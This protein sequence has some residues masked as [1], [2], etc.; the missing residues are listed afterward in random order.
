MGKRRRT[1][2]LP[3][4]GPAPALDL[5]SFITRRFVAPAS[6]LLVTIVYFAGFV[7]SGNVIEGI[8][9]RNEFYLGKEPMSKKLADLAPENWS[10]YLGGTPMSGFRKPNYFPLYPVYLFTTYHR[11]LGWRYFFAMFAAGYTMYLCAR[12]G[13]GIRPLPAWVTGAAY[14]FSPTLMTFIY[15]G[16]EGKMLV[17]GLLP[18]MVWSLYRGMDTRR[19]IYALILGAGVAAGIYTPHLQMLY[20][21]LL[22]LGLLFV[23]R[24]VQAYHKE[25]DAR[26]LAARSAIA[27]GG[28]CVGLAVGAVGTFPAYTYTKTES[29]RAGSDGAGVGLQ[30]AQSWSLH[31]EEIASLLVPEFVH[32]FRPGDRQNLYWGRNALKLNAEYFGIVSLLLALAALARIRGDDRIL[33]LAVVGTFALLFSLGP[34]TPVHSLFYHAVPGMNVLRVPGMI[35]F[36]IAFPAILLGGLL[37]DRISTG[38]EADDLKALKIATGALALPLLALFAAPTGAMDA[39]R[40]I[41]WPSISSEKAAIL[42]RNGTFLQNGA[43]LGLLWILGAFA[44]MYMGYRGRV[45]AQTVLVAILTVTAIDT[46]RIDKQF[47]R[48]LDPS[49]YPDPPVLHPNITR[50]LA[51]DDDLYRVLIGGTIQIPRTDLVTVPYHE[52]FSVRRYDAVTSKHLQSLPIL[53]LLNVRYLVTDRPIQVASFTSVAQDR[54]AHLYRNENALPFFYLVGSTTVETNEATIIERLMAPDF[55]LSQT[56]I[57]EVD[58]GAALS[59]SEGRVELLAFD[60]RAGRL[61]FQVASQTTQL[62]IVCQNY[63]PCW[64]AFVDGTPADLLRANYLWQGVVVPPGSHTVDLVYEDGLAVVCRWISFISFLGLV[65]GLIVLYRKDTREQAA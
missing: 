45:A 65:V 62:L 6:F 12:G 28:I 57:L 8:D 30:Y 24:A 41:A 49:H 10:R 56:A 50:A 19:P 25:K 11:Y 64:S 40:G 2:N 61:S 13:L 20:Y 22:A 58:P 31:P 3:A 52:P 35:A 53:N 1:S 7:F 23:V 48:F 15:P 21:V 46:W 34:H 38:L 32:F 4:Q 39:W 55:D 59:S 26:L 9:T 60:E 54:G 63:F 36:L 44:L 17:I 16:Q 37:L 42:V 14:A 43:G 29:R 18:L 27:A 5:D 51:A 47:L 33:P